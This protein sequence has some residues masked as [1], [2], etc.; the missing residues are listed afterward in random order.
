MCG[1]GGSHQIRV[2]LRNPVDGGEPA[3]GYTVGGEAKIHLWNREGEAFETLSITPS[4]HWVGH[5][6]GWIT[7]GKIISA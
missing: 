5:W 7:A 4:L 1:A 2:P 3:K 6:H